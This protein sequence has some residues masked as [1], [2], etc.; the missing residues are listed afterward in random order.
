MTIDIQQT[1]DADWIDLKTIRLQSLMDSPKAFGLTVEAASAYTDDQWRDRAGNRTPPMYFVARD[2]GNPVGLIGGVKASDDFELI[3]MWVSP[4][5][6]GHGVGRALVAKVLAAA[7]SRGES[8][9]CLFVS[10]LNKAACAL[11]EAMG[12][13]FTPDVEALESYPEVIVQRMLA[14]LAP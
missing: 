5:H 11:Y 14:K 7:A 3:A 9:V 12:F 13:C 6:R 2:E 4:S 10:P 1:T 8:E